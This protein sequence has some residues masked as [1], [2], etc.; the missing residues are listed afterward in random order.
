MN[1]IQTKAFD[2]LNNSTQI[3]LK[4]LLDKNHDLSQCSTKVRDLIEKGANYARV[5]EIEKAINC[6]KQAAI[7]DPQYIGSRTR[8]VKAYRFGGFHAKALVEGGQALALTNEPKIRSEIYEFLGLAAKDIFDV[9]PTKEHLDDAIEFYQCAI[10]E[11]SESIHAR[12]NIVCAYLSGY[13]DTN[14]DQEEK[15]KLLESARKA[16]GEVID[17]ARRDPKDVSDPEFARAV[18]M[19]VHDAK[20][21]LA[22]LGEWWQEKLDELSEIAAQPEWRQSE[23]TQKTSEKSTR[24][25]SVRKALVTAA[26]ALAIAGG[27]VVYDVI[28]HSEQTPVEQ[29][30]TPKMQKA[31]EADKAKKAAKRE[32]Q[33][34]EV[35]A[36]ETERDWITIT[37]VQRDWIHL[38]EVERDWD[39][40]T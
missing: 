12:W 23:K 39:S 16:I 8:L 29:I 21:K 6:F 37:E 20:N 3:L 32:E 27:P 40:L 31:D 7:L 36:K 19:I 35:A 30:Q 26:F 14:L 28:M 4:A 24:K 18:I 11:T 1:E 2:I 38:A 33:T 17:F 5:N 34:S 9:S 15:K 25:V 13:K 10:A 22:G